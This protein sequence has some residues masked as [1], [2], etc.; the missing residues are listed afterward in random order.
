MSDARLSG[1]AVLS[2]ERELAE[3]ANIIFQVGLYP[4]ATVRNICI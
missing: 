2:I 1:L 3:V 4:H